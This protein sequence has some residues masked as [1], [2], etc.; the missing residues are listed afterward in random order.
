MTLTGA[1]RELDRQM[2]VRIVLKDSVAREPH[3]CCAVALVGGDAL[4]IKHITPAE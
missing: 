2:P 4:T 1:L 3:G